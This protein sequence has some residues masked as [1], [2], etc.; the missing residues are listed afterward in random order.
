MQIIWVLVVLLV[1]LVTPSS[2]S[3]KPSE[4]LWRV[5]P[6]FLSLVRNQV[7]E[8][9]VKPL[10]ELIVCPEGPPVCQFSKIQEA[11]EAAPATPPITDLQSP[12]EI[13]LIRI[14]P[15]IYEE[16]LTILKNVWLQGAS[17]ES[18]ILRRPSSSQDSVTAFVAG[19]YYTAVAFQNLTF[20]G[21]VQVVGS[22]RGAFFNN[23]FQADSQGNGGMQ[24]KGEL[25]LDIISNLFLDVPIVLYPV[26][27]LFE[28]HNS[29]VIFANRFIGSEQ[30]VAGINIRQSSRISLNSN[31]IR[32]FS[33]GVSLM[34]YNDGIELVANTLEDNIV[35]IGSCCGNG[36]VEIK[37]NRLQRHKD[38]ALQ[39]SRG[40][41]GGEYL[42]TENEIINNAKGIEWGS[43]AHLWIVGNSITQNEIGLQLWPFNPLQ[44]I[45]KSLENLKECR[46][47][48]ISENKTDYVI[49]GIL[50]DLLRQRCEGH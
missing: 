5:S 34:G 29:V 44:D 38:A 20:E 12:L 33:V 8:L 10:V 31:Q 7:Q 9:P 36:S 50:P 27:P 21:E 19:S 42:I 30:K 32:G 37:M 14:A 24:L 48:K 18:V 41:L 3:K 11:I 22:V 2:M 4:V 43:L 15:G 1:M 45:A 26:A 39:L 6:S 49:V 16:R 47:N 46:N 35:G 28:H 23:R 13:P 25:A 17:Q 40:S